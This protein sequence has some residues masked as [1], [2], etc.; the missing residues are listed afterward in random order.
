MTQRPVAAGLLDR[1]AVGTVAP[2]HA[3]EAQ[4]Q[5]ADVLAVDVLG[6]GT[7]LPDR[8]VTNQDWAR[9]LDTDDDW[10][11]SRTGI[12]E[13]RFAGPGESTGSLA[14]AAARA[15][16]ADADLDVVSVATPADVPVAVA[17]AGAVRELAAV[18]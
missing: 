8:V 9:T 15:A 13:R 17:A 7:A 14:L 10:I 16:L 3:G 18:A 12:A 2:A 6:I 4:R 11:R 1:T 5:R